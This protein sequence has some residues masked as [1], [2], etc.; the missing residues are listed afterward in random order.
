MK[1][2]L[3]GLL[4]LLPVF[5]HGQ[6]CGSNVPSFTVDLT[7]SPDSVWTS[8]SISRQG[9]CCNARGSD[10]CI[11]FTVTL[12]SNALGLKL[13]VSGGTGTTYYSVGCGNSTLVGTIN[14]LNGV[15]PHEVTVCKPGNNAQT[16]IITSI[17]K[18]HPLPKIGYATPSCPEDVEV[19]GLTLSSIKWET[20]GGY[21]SFLNCTVGC[22][23]IIFTP[24][25]SPLPNYVDVVVSGTSPSTCYSGIYHD[26]FRVYLAQDFSMTL[27]PSDTIA[28][29]G[30]SVTL[31]AF[32]S[33]GFAPY[34]YTWN[35]SSTADSLYVPSGNYSIIATDSLQCLTSYD[36]AVVK[37]DPPKPAITGDSL[38]CEGIDY[39]YSTPNTPGH[40]YVWSIN[41]GSFSTRRNKPSVIAQFTSAGA[42]T[43]TVAE[44]STHGCTNTSTKTVW[45]LPEPKTSPI[46]HRP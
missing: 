24:Y 36:T 13:E 40:S 6:N 22:Q 19:R 2:L 9:K 25:G 27:Q 35:T 20:I 8:P 21:D 16:Y 45:V 29:P 4:F 31:R 26:T 38:I 30:D 34:S 14:C 15:G 5:A 12:D 39:S 41:T 3:L 18:P 7:G 44:T 28:C 1:G 32:S 10:V 37:V 42:N 43:I 23:D 17:E 33:G 11:S 46:H